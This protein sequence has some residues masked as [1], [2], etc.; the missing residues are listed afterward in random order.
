M[1]GKPDQDDKLRAVLAA[2]PGQGFAVV[3]G[4]RFENLPA[5]CKAHRLFARSL[6]LDH[7]D[8]EV[9]KAGPWLIGLAQA[10]DATER[11]LGLV[12]KEPAAVYWCC[13]MGEAILYRHLRTLNMAR[14]PS[15]SADGEAGPPDPSAATTYQTV[16]F[17]HYDPR[18]LG[19]IMP[20]LD[21]A[22]FARVL[23]P[24]S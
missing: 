14:V 12:G 11:L 6:F 4:A 16:M 3:D 13:D 21:A 23:G 2:F 7:A 10:P 1:T 17:R 20:V 18:V 9:E 19:S 24:A 22:Q 15:W 5:L 8:I